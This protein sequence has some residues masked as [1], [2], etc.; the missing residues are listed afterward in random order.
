[1]HTEPDEQIKFITDS[2]F[3]IFKIKFKDA[4]NLRLFYALKRYSA[5]LKNKKNENTCNRRIRDQVELA[6]CGR[7]PK[8]RS[9]Y[10]RRSVNTAEPFRRN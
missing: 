3:R 9:G 2:V 1:M 4:I 8:S 5:N 10:R 7:N 6:H